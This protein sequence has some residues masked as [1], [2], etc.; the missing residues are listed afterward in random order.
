MAGLNDFDLAAFV[1]ASCVRHGVPVK[2]TDMGVHRDVALLLSGRSV[3]GA[4]PAASGRQARSDPPNEINP[5]GIEAATTN[6][7][8]GND[9]MVENGTNNG[10]LPGEVEFGPLS[11]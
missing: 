8:R 1:E 9:G 2:V 3:R 7:R 4:A 6:I 5:L 11:A 10:V